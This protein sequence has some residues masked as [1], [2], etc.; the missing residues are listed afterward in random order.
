MYMYMSMIIVIIDYFNEHV[1]NTCTVGVI[2]FSSHI[3]AG[4]Q[5]VGVL[6]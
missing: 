2:L 6:D 3:F 4:T 1:G 5:Q